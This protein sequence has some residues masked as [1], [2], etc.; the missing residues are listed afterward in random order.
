MRDGRPSPAV[1]SPRWLHPTLPFRALSFERRSFERRRL[2]RQRGRNR[3]TLL[4][5]R[6]RPD[7][8]RSS[9]RLILFA[10]RLTSS[11]ASYEAPTAGGLGPA[12]SIAGIG[13]SFQGPRR[14]WSRSEGR[15]KLGGGAPLVKHEFKKSTA[16]P[17][18]LFRQETADQTCSSSGVPEGK[19]AP[20]REG[21][22]GACGR[23]APPATG[24]IRAKMPQFAARAA[25]VGGPATERRTRR[26]IAGQR[27]D[28]RTI[29]REAPAPG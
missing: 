21:P 1:F 8:K 7:M 25:A 28:R 3:W 20:R 19:G 5:R 29:G 27:P 11:A 17:R 12:I 6:H 26:A 18:G 23:P 14:R 9:R 15:R 24:Q 10:Y 2:A 13:L 22:S 4:V 16:S